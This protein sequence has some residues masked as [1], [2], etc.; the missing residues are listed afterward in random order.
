MSMDKCHVTGSI[1][2]PAGKAMVNATVKFTMTTRDQDGT[3]IIM[4]SPVVVKI[5]DDGQVEVDL[6]PNSRGHAGT[7]YKVSVLAA[8]VGNLGMTSYPEWRVVVPDA[9]TANLTDISELVPPPVVDDARAAALEAGEYAVEARGYRDEVKTLRDEVM[10]LADPLQTVTDNIASIDA[11]AT[12]I[13]A[14]KAAPGAADSAAAWAEGHEPGGV[15]T[16]SAKEHAA[17]A[18]A[19]ETASAASATKAA[20]AAAVMSLIFGA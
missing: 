5:G 9:P 20:R 14:I 12:D 1:L 17:A 7:Y 18:G 13:D 19:S 8:A 11:A 4:P 2:D 10:P 16:K 15:G 3:T 6:W